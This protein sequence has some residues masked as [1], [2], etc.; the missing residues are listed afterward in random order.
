MTVGFYPKAIVKNIPPGVNDPTIVPCGV[1]LHVRDGL[2]DS[3][4][5]YFDGPSGGIESHFYVRHD[6][7]I[8]QYRSVYFEADANLDGNSFIFAGKRVGFV[9]IETEGR[10]AGEWTAAQL[11]SIKAIILWVHGQ[12]QA[13]GVDM[14]LAPCKA[15]NL[16]GVGYHT[17]WGSPS[18]WTPVAKSCPGPDRIKQFGAV[19]VPWMAEQSKPKPSSLR[20]TTAN[21]DFGLGH[22]ADYLAHLAVLSDVILVQE[23][24]NVHLADVLPKGWRALQDTTSAATMGSAICYRVEAVRAGSSALTL[25]EGSKPFWQGKRVGMLTRYMATAH[26][27]D[28]ET[29]EWFYA[30]A[31]HLPPA[32]FKFLQPGMTRRLRKVLKGHPHA[33]AGLDANQPLTHLAAKLDL[34]C[35]GKGIVGL[36]VGKGLRVAVGAVDHWGIQHNATDHPAVTIRTV[37]KAL[38]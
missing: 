36:L 29:G 19:I 10:A 13:S 35:Y 18:H 16:P 6:G 11:V 20:W 7:T 4:H 33:V 5:D 26:L 37:R 34:D 14:P 25:V 38:P 2:G 27:Q 3:L 31:A 8:E 21:L 12:A 24:K 30:V 23:A 15:W 28:R 17:M 1:V 22:D 9:S 32:R